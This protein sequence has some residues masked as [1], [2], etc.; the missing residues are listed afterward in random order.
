MAHTEYIICLTNN[1]WKNKFLNRDAFSVVHNINTDL[2]LRSR[3]KVFK[4]DTNSV[5]PYV[6]R[7]PCKHSSIAA[8]QCNPSPRTKIISLPL[9]HDI[10]LQANKCKG[11]I[12][13]FNP[14]FFFVL[15][16]KD[17]CLH[18]ALWGG[19]NK[20]AQL[21]GWLCPL[22]ALTCSPGQYFPKAAHLYST[23]SD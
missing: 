22:N 9:S 1:L 10:C 23:K 11:L 5:V 13:L 2:K 12:L 20:N 3:T 17:A 4:Q 16:W 14:P 7:S 8:W 15:L 19:R 6:A 21:F 18:A